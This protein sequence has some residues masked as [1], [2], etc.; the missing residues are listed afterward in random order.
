M[1]VVAAGEIASE[2]TAAIA[3]AEEISDAYDSVVSAYRRLKKLFDSTPA[4]YEPRSVYNYTRSL[5][6][7]EPS[8]FIQSMTRLQNINYSLYYEREFARAIVSSLTANRVDSFFHNGIFKEDTTAVILSLSP[9]LVPFSE[10]SRSLSLSRHPTHEELL[11][12][13]S[14]YYA[15]TNNLIA[16]LADYNQIFDK[17]KYEMTFGLNIT[18]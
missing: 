13:R 12:G 18:D 4:H 1:A 5:I 6:F 7:V 16:L 15:S 2:I 11:H 8:R 3:A 10:L 17:Q 14:T 9:F